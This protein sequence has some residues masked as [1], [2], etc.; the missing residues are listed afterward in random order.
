MKEWKPNDYQG[1]RRDQVER[2]YRILGFSIVIGWL[3]IFFLGLYS[4]INYIF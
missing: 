4:L 2:N 1:R 3:F